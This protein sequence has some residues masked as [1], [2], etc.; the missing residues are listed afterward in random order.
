MTAGETRR[1]LRVSDSSCIDRSNAC[2]SVGSITQ[3]TKSS[4]DGGI[5]MVPATRTATVVL[6]YGCAAGDA[7]RMSTC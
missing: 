7:Q 6:E 3:D 1:A 2:A 4:V 5:M